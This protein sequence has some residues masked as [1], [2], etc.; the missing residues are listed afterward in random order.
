MTRYIIGTVARMDLPMTPNQEGSRAFR[1][2]LEKTKKENLQSERDEVL[3]VN[4]EDIRNFAALIEK[5]ISQNYI[6]VYG[7]EDA[8]NQNK[9][10]FISTYKL[11]K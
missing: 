8:V 7:N 5:M 11:I 9:D 3:S 6:C 2:H 4:D 10:L 1:M